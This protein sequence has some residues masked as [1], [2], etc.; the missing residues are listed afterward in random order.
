MEDSIQ[1]LTQMFNNLELNEF[2]E[3]NEFNELNELNELFAKLKIDTG[4]NSNNLFNEFN[5]LNS[6]NEKFKKLSIEEKIVCVKNIIL[7][8]INILISRR[9]SC[10]DPSSYIIQTLKPIF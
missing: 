6:L 4:N 8:M 10:Q 7:E 9:Y 5:E 1:E 3:F 2:N